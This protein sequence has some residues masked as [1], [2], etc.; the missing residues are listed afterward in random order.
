MSATTQ[1]TRS[2]PAKFYGV[3]RG[4][5]PGVYES[6]SDALAQII[7]F[8]NASA[9]KFKTEQEAHDFVLKAAGNGIEA[10]EQDM[11]P[12]AEVSVPLSGY[13][14]DILRIYTDGSCLN[15]GQLGA[16]AGMGVYFGPDDA[17][18]LSEALPGKAQTNQRA[19]VMAIMRALESVPFCQPLLICSDSMYAKNCIEIWSKKWRNPPLN[20]DMTPGVPWTNS[21]GE[22]VKNR[23]LLEPLLKHID[24]RAAARVET[25][26][27]W[28][29][30]HSEDVGNAGADALA[31]EASR[32]KQ[33]RLAAKKCRRRARLPSSG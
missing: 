19:E 21:K 31:V 11:I 33:A 3:Q 16:V 4:H 29:K 20:R 22:P 17:R 28:V 9:R 5:H 23:D 13:Q 1:Q 25:K 26:F 30:G 6:Y 32:K 15:N 7:K 24:N 8:Q 2:E 18:N 27:E 14:P 12:Q 10:Q